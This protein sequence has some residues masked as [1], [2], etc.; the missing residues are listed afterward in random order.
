MAEKRKWIGVDLDGT[1]AYYDGWRG[2]DHIGYPI[3]AMVNRVKEWLKRG[4]D[5]RI[6][7]ARVATN[8]AMERTHIENRIKDWCRRNIG[9]E[10]PIT[11]QKD[12]QMEEL[13]DDR[14]RR[15]EK[16][17]GRVLA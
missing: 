12:M 17:T 7:T 15:V 4:K 11:N 10:L 9:R 2:T 13:W 14:V 3:D 1:L 6:M 16:N 5:V 8:N